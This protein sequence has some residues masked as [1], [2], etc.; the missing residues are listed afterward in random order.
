MKRQLLHTVEVWRNPETKEWH[1]RFVHQN[2][3]ELARQS[4]GVTKRSRAMQSASVAYGLGALVQNGEGSREWIPMNR[5]DVRLL[6][7]S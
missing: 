1:H 5:D 3:K 2:S 4:E 7:L 6:V